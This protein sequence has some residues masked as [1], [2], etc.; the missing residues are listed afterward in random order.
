VSE[1]LRSVNGST[2]PIQANFG[3][4]PG[5]V[6]CTRADL[7]GDGDDDLLYSQRAEMSLVIWPN[8]GT[9]APSFDL[10]TRQTVPYGN[11]SAFD[12]QAQ[13]AWS[14]IDNDGDLDICFPRQDDSKFA[15]LWGG[16]PRDGAPAIIHTGSWAGTYQGGVVQFEA[17]EPLPQGADH[18]E[19]LTWRRLGSGTDP[20]YDRLDPIWPGDP[21]GEGNVHLTLDV[22]VPAIEG[23]P[24]IHFFSM[25]W[26]SVAGPAAEP[27][28]PARLYGVEIGDGNGSYLS[29]LPGHG[30][31]WHIGGGIGA[32]GT[33]CEIVQ[34]PELPQDIPP[35]PRF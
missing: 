35:R 14:D 34:I 32:L 29:G 15:V 4:L 20:L 9:T 6:A 13:P 3:A 26:V 25:R 11:G 16:L 22:P 1:Y 5:I 17:D 18:L 7:D 8:T 28:F 21:D 30:P 12:N 24:N 27:R 23:T 19:V 10:S 33:V 2:E 31:I